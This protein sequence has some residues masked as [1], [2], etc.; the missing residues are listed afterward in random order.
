MLM[1]TRNTLWMRGMLELQQRPVVVIGDNNWEYIYSIR[2]KLH[3][4]RGTLRHSAV[5]GMAFSLELRHLAQIGIHVI[6]MYVDG[7]FIAVIQ[8]CVLDLLTIA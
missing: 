2:Y 4:Y 6:T 5:C 1:R 7:T 3:L 8:N